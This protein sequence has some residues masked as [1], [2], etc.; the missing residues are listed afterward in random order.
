MAQ[1]WFDA[2]SEQKVFDQYA[3]NE[4]ANTRY[5]AGATPELASRVGQIYNQSPWMTPGQVLSLAKGNASPATVDVASQAQARR[6]PSQLDPNKPEDKGFFERN[7]FDKVKTASRW[8]FASMDILK[9]LSNNVASQIFSDNDPAGFDGWFKSTQL[10][11]MLADSEES[12]EGWF[13]GGKAAEKQAERARRV[14]G[15]ING[16]AFTIGRG[17]ANVVFTPGSKAYNIASGLLDAVVT[18]GTDVTL[19]GGKAFAAS[20]GYSSLS[21]LKSAGAAIQGVRSADELS[22]IQK[23]IEVCNSRQ[24]WSNQSRIIGFGWIKVFEV[25]AERFSCKKACI[26]PC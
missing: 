15:T 18:L 19:V 25:L 11:T 16:S 7:V 4:T 17:A 3:A 24:R 8:S 26:K 21:E 14:R 13:F 5:K 12:G 2:L 1:G 6:V 9:D 22:A 10:G 20:K 23:D